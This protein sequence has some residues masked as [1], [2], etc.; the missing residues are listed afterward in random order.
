VLRQV[1]DGVLVH[2]SEFC[3][4]NA[5]VVLGRAGVLLID[6]G[7]LGHEMACLAN[8]L[9]D[10]G[11]TVVAGFSTHP[12]WDHLLWHARLG[13]A[14]RYG[15]ARCAAFVRDRLS[16]ADAKARIAAQLIPPDIAEQVPLDLLGLITG[17]PAE[18][19]QI[20]WDGPQVRIIEHQA[21]APGHAALLI[22][23]RGV[24]VAG[25]MLSDVLIPMLNLNGTADPIQDY[26]AALRLLEGAAGDVDVLVPGHGSIGGADQV[27]T[28]ID[29]DRAY[30]HALRD[31]QVPSDPRVGPEAQDGWDWVAG[32]HAGQLQRLAQGSERDGTPG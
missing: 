4:S 11:Q 5:V 14:P 15:T 9:S 17:L 20:P 6:P 24:L 29:Q 28:R 13:K 1:A 22:E 23:E 26:L 25:D 2:E 27:Q 10:S 7:V 16:D 32:V 19:A 21:H 8:D 18:T 12:H 30:V 31:A 3:Q